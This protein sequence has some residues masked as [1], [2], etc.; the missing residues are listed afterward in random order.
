METGDGAMGHHSRRSIFNHITTYPGVTFVT[1]KNIYQ[2]SDG[3]LR[4][5]LHY[6]E[7][8]SLISGKVI[9]GRRCYYPKDERHSGYFDPDGNFIGVPLSEIQQRILH[10]IK[11]NP[12]ANQK[13]IC[14][15]VKCSRFTFNYNIGTLLTIGLVRKWKD[16]RSTRFSYIDQKTLKKE[17]LKRAAEDLLTGKIDEVLFKRIRARLEK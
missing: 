12:G 7:R 13:E 11:G 6:L 15:L 17:I 4:Y 2:M 9:N 16:G 1:L 14:R 8:K 10:R 3:T 5:H